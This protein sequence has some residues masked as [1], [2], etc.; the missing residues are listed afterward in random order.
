MSSERAP[1]FVMAFGAKNRSR[2][3][4]RMLGRVTAWIGFGSRACI[5]P[6]TRITASFL[7]APGAS[8]ANRST[9]ADAASPSAAARS[10]ESFAP[11]AILALMHAIAA[12]RC[13]VIVAAGN[14][15]NVTAAVRAPSV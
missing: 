6:A 1:L 14:G 3:S 9:R 5:H 7:M 8:G 12:G 4:N 15:L 13:A 11:P 10:S 2:K